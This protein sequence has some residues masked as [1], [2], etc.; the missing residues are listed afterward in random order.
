MDKKLCLKTTPS[1]RNTALFI[2]NPTMLLNSSTIFL[3]S[4]LERAT[5]ELVF[6]KTL[7]LY[8]KR[9]SDYCCKPAAIVCK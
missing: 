7:G 1:I 8:A 5:V 4:V 3:G 2:K 9:E 6:R